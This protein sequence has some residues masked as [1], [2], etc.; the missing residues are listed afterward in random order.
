M[1][2][3]PNDTSMKNNTSSQPPG[4]RTQPEESKNT[5]DARQLVARFRS[6]KDLYDYLIFQ[7]KILKINL[8]M[9]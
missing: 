7:S 9:I 3:K 1:S 4:K 8:T 5:M 6:K 2:S